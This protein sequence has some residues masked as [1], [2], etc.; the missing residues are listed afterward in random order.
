MD[1]VLPALPNPTGLVAGAV[2]AA[3]F[4][5]PP[6]AGLPDRRVTVHGVRQD[7]ADLAAYTRVCGFALR[8]AVPATW[9][10]VLSFPL[11][12][13]LM[14]KRDF[15]FGLVGLVHVT[16]TIE[17]LRPVL[18]TEALDITT[19]AVNLAPH[20]RGVVF[21]L[22]SEIHAGHEPVWRGTSTYLARGASLTTGVPAASAHDPDER[23]APTAEPGTSPAPPTVQNERPAPLPA[24]ATWRLSADL[25]RRYAAVAGDLNPIHLAAITARPFGFP[26][27]IVQGMWTYA[28]VLAA[29]DG[30]LPA[31]YRADLR[32]L[33]PIPLPSTVRFAETP[34]TGPTPASTPAAGFRVSVTNRAGKPCLVGTIT[35]R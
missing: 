25:G 32:F 3:A 26:S 30:R 22:V 23:P 35:A 31:A 20:R 10:H 5:P 11:Q 6:S 9:L 16:N 19:G 27:A 4:R 17:Q 21:D 2:L 15:P 29:L 1:V 34:L 33:T 12:T 14:S 24:T 18:V 7:V 13:Y 28:R 8:D